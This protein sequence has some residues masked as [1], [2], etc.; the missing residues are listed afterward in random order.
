MEAELDALVARLYGLSRSQVEHVFSTF[1]RGW[2]YK[3]RLAAVLEYFDKI[4]GPL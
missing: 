2:D 1:H 3:S 4:E